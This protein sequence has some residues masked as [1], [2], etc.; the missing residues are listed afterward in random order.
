MYGVLTLS[1]KITNWCNLNCAHCC[2]CS[3]ANNPTNFMPLTRAEQYISEFQEVPYHIMQHYTI[4]GGEGLAPYQF[5]DFDYIPTILSCIYKIDG[6]PTIKTNGVWGERYNMRVDILK[7]LA[8]S[9][10]TGNKLLTLDISVDEFHNNLKGVANIVADVV[11]SDYLLPA[12]R[13]CLVGFNTDGTRN[14]MAKLRTQL[15]ERELHT[16][17]LP[18]DDW[19][20]YRDDNK[21]MRVVVGAETEIYDLGRAKQNNVYTATGDPAGG[22]VNCLS[23][24]NNNLATLNYLYAEQIAGRNL[25]CVM[26]SLMRRAEQNGK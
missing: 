10:R 2:E 3:G 6:I 8:N 19:A 13:I 20:V 4:S 26:D 18:N 11:Q 15:E 25:K 14:N 7:S 5:G 21:G 23:V 17:V 9:A 16:E 24:D 12:I 1:L 22:Y